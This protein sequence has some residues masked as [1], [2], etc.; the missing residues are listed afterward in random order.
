MNALVV[1]SVTKSFGSGKNYRRAVDNVS[2]SVEDGEVVGLLGMNGAGKST[3][4]KMCSGLLVPDSGSI[5]IFG[6]DITTDGVAAKSL[7]NV[8]PQETAVAPALSVRENLELIACIY[9]ASKASAREKAD[10]I[11][12]RLKLTD[13][14]NDHAKKLSG[15]LMRRLSI[16]M[17][18][19][20]SPRLIFLDEPTLGLDVVSRRELWR[21]IRETSEHCAVVLTT[22]YLE[23]AEALCN[24]IAIMANGKI[25]A[26]G[27][28][29]E[30][31]SKAGADNFEDAFL[32][33]SGEEVRG[34]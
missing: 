16:G 23:E 3:T 15:G 34:E 22:H 1:D 5:N 18:L 29:D 10:E 8:S 17:A 12:R 31:K 9:G 27:S 33:L 19:I 26:T 21:Y 2:L 28:P 24:R 25:V 32:M 4:V 7:I 14:A 11:M 30:L 6:H 13:R 20:S